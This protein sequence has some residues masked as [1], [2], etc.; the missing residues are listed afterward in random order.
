M[1]RGRQKNPTYCPCFL[2]HPAHSEIEETKESLERQRE[3]FESIGGKLGFLM[4]RFP[5]VNKLI[6]DISASKHRDNIV[7]AF[8]IASCMFFTFFYVMAKR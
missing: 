1:W 8:V 6:K 7:L 3:M 2:F 4:E 5:A